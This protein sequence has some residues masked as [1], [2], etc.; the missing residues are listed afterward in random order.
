MGS[1]ACASPVL[2]VHPR[3]DDRA[4]LRNRHDL[5]NQL[6]GVVETVVL[7]DGYHVVTLGRQRQLVVSR[8]L[9]FIA[10]LPARAADRTSS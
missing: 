1:P 7:D 8:T 9:D 2:S 5:Q 6:G 4:S 10:P 3:E